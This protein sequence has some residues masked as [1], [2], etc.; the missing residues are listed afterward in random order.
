MVKRFVILRK[1]PGIST[2]EFHR[3]WEEVHG[4]LIACIPG[5]RKYTQYHVR[6]EANSAEDDPIDGIAELWFDDEQ[7]QKA[8]YATPEYA[9]VVEDEPNLFA[10]NTHS[11]HPVME[12][13]TVQIVRA[14]D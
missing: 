13:R 3:Y 7:S 11:I 4:P 10:M 8:A 9:R 14:G 6:S 1:R 2:A 5:L 12:L